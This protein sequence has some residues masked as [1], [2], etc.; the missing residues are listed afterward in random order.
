MVQTS[1]TDEFQ[2][3]LKEIMTPTTSLNN[4]DH[5]SLTKMT[6][7]ASPKPVIAK[8]ATIRIISTNNSKH[9]VSYHVL[10]IAEVR[11]ENEN[12]TIINNIESQT[13][14]NGDHIS[15]IKQQVTDLKTLVQSLSEKTELNDINLS[16]WL[17]R[18]SSLLRNIPL[19]DIAK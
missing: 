15:D 3:H 17:E 11:T 14:I 6:V 16:V 4:E 2:Q 8:T 9:R 19:S 10:D 12:D 13:E 5:Q 7:Y 1:L 18:R